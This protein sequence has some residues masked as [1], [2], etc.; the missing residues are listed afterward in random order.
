M[1]KNLIKDIVDNSYIVLIIID[2]SNST[3][4]EIE[5][6]KCII[7]DIN[8]RKKAIVNNNNNKQYYSTSYSMFY[9][10]DINTKKLDKNFI[11]IL[12]YQGERMISRH[13]LA[14]SGFVLEIKND[15]IK[16][17]KSR[18]SIHGEYMDIKKLLRRIKIKKLN[19]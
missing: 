14:V 15:H 13:N 6:L 18:T 7:K 5:M 11:N 2:M 12:I 8:K 16:I 1:Y 9:G 3:D 19:K 17:I 10:D 4:C